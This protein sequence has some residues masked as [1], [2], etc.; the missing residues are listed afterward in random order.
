MFTGII[1]QIGIIRHIDLVL[2]NKEIYIQSS[3]APELQIDQSIAHNGVCLTVET[4]GHDW[5][6]CTVIAETLSLTT[7]SDAQIGDQ[8]NLER[9]IQAHS[10]LDGHFVQGHV[11]HTAKCIS[12]VELN[13]SWTYRFEFPWVNRNLIV[14]KGSICIHGVSLTV[15]G[16]AGDY[17]EVSII[18]Y[19]FHHTNFKFIRPGSSVNIEYDILGKYIQRM[20]A[21]R[22]I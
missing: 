22:T 19:T 10:R 13:G 20:M 5:H 9:C 14:S 1:E 11:D 17:F 12:V 3:L 8:I 15:S 2:S 16:L 6:R 4:V 7:F 21:T 18:P